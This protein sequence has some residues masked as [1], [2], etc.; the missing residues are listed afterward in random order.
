VQSAQER[1]AVAASSADADGAG[2]S[3]YD[4]LTEDEL[5]EVITSLEVEAMRR[6]RDYEAAHRARPGVLA[7]LDHQLSLRRAFGPR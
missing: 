7:A 3:L 1:R 2:S 6:L 5:L 4:D